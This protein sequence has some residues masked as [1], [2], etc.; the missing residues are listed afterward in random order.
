MKV[1]VLF[2]GG[3]DSSYAL[4]RAMAKEEVACLISVMSENKESY[5]FHTPNIELVKLQS[6]AAEM[7]LVYKK[8]K[9][10]KEEELSDLRE[11]IINAKERYG[12]EGIVTGAVESVYQASRIQKICSELGI[13]CFNPLWKRDQREILHDII[14]LGFEVI[15]TGVFAGHMGEEWLGR[16][17]DEETAKELFLLEEKYGISPTGEG[18]EIETTVLDAPFFRKKIAIE[19]TEKHFDSMSGIMRIK[20][21]FLEGKRH[22][23]IPK[24]PERKLDGDILLIDMN[25]RKN[26]LSYEEFVLPVAKALKYNCFVRHW[27]EVSE[28]DLSRC[29]KVV[30]SGS[31]LGDTTSAESPEKFSWLKGFEKPVLGIC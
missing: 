1:G 12:I 2:S 14:S 6:E 15:I 20:K 3:K 16:R 25:E 28:H 19:K 8:T 22:F 17:I 21:A 30:L 13:R 23:S 5:M 9:G 7:P 10:V 27:S 4:F 26:S 18:G 31:P 11:A 29:K 24:I